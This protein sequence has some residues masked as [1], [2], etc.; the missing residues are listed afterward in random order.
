MRG[1]VIVD[2]VY[3]L[4]KEYDSTLLEDDGREIVVA[5]K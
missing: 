4:K 2:T 1:H 5:H 3:L